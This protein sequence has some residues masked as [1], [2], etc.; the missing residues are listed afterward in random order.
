MQSLPMNKHLLNT[1][2]LI[3]MPRFF[4][5]RKYDWFISQ[6][7]SQLQICSKSFKDILVRFKVSQTC[8]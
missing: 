8:V 5:I 6:K 1:V 7:T 2:L 3:E 4:I